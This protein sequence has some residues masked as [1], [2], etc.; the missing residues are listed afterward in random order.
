MLD[1]GRMLSAFFDTL[2]ALFIYKIALLLKSHN[3]KFALC[4][5]FVYAI[6]FFPIQNAHFFVVDPL[7]TFF[8]T[9]TLY[10]LIYYIKNPSIKTLLK[11]SFFSAGAITTKFTGILLFP[12]I[13]ITLVIG[14]FRISQDK[15]NV[16]LSFGK[17]RVTSYELQV[18]LFILSFLV[19]SFL[20]MPY[21]YVHYEQFI[22]EIS[23]QLKMNSDPFIFPYTLQYVNTLP[24]WYYVKN[25]FLW[26]MGPV[27]SLLALFGLVGF[28]IKAN[29]FIKRTK[30]RLRIT[31]KE[32]RVLLLSLYFILHFMI[33][34]RSAVK[35]MR[36]MLPLY[37]FFALLAGYGLY[38]I[39]K[40]RSLFRF[41]PVS[42]T[43]L[44]IATIWTLTFMLIYTRP[45]TRIQASD[46]IYRNIPAGAII[47]VEHWDD[48]LP[49]FSGAQYT[50]EI[51]ELYNQDTPEKWRKINRQLANSDYIV[52]ASNRLYVPLMKLT[53][54]REL[55]ENHCYPKTSDY[56]QNLFNGSLGFEK[57]AEFTSFP[58]IK[59]NGLQLTI[60]D[61][62]ADES[63][64]VYDHPKVMIFKRTSL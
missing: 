39:S 34:G 21:G 10:Q 59:I 35:F 29:Q 56:Y 41:K 1:V 30:S 4:A 11:I 38:R 54:C 48:Q 18:F 8:T 64:T 33:I 55:P 43:L 16:F 46:W 53:N 7:L 52:I 27:I 40:H 14:R 3:K 63:F 60:D 51:L 2:T 32:L 61:S 13:L 57:V 45:T 31:N 9:A 20:F 37:P 58:G 47:A 26:G 12:I 22:K 44:V 49:L 19:F 6:A 24:Y 17:L 15:L 5:A 36:Y 25:I 23:L 42:T 50:F 28:I 62:E